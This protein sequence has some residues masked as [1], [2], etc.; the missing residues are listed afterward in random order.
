MHDTD[1]LAACLGAAKEETE[2][3]VDTVV[4]QTQRLKS[5][6]VD[7]IEVAPL[8]GGDFASLPSLFTLERLPVSE[9][10]KCTQE[11]ADSWEH[12]TGVTLPKLSSPVQLLIGSNAPSL[13]VAEDVRSPTD[14]QKPYAL[15][16]CLGWFVIGSGGGTVGTYSS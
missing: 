4:H 6:Q 7:E 10:N 14:S 1:D 16:S 13:L 12:L 3:S 5:C 2:I 9:A 15:R 11:M 8:D